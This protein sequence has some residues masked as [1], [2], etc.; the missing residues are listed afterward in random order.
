MMKPASLS[1]ALLLAACSTE[2]NNTPDGLAGDQLAPPPVRFS[3]TVP[4]LVMTTTAR[5]QISGA[6]AN[7][8][9]NLVV[10]GNV[11]AP[12]LCPAATAPVC[13]DVAN[14]LIS[15]GSVM[16]DASGRAIFNLP[17]PTNAPAQVEFQAYGAV[18]GNYA[19]SNGVLTRVYPAAGDAD[20]DGLSNLDE[21]QHG[22]RVAVADTDG[23]GFSDGQER[24]MGTD[25]LDP[26]DPSPDTD[27]DGLTDAEEHA[28]GTDPR[29]PDTD[30][31]GLFDG[32]ELAAGTDPLNPDTDA[33]GLLDGEEVHAAGTDPTNPDTDD[34]GLLDGEEIHL[35]GTDPRNPDSD[36][37]GLFDGD[38]VAFGSDPNVVDTDS[39]GLEDGDEFLYDT[40]P[41]NPDTD[42]DGLLDGAEIMFG[43]DPLDAD[44]D[45]DGIGDGEETSIGTDPTNPDTDGGGESDGDEVAAGRDPLNP[46]DDG[47]IQPPA[48]HLVINEVDY[49]MPSTDNLEFI[50]IFNPT[51]API[52]LNG[53]AVVL[54]NGSNS[55]EYLR[56]QLG[57]VAPSL[58][59]GAYLVVANALVTVPAGTLRTTI[60]DN[61]V[62][63]GAPDGVALIDTNTLTVIDALSYEG[64]IAAAIITGFPTTVSLVEGTATTANDAS[65]PQGLSRLPNGTD[66]NNA[67]TDWAL[68]AP[69]PGAANL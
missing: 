56:V 47:G 48:G 43:A 27:N 38:E 46:A 14:P 29:N 18:G 20:G 42:G 61:I 22:T 54:V 41:T 12:G 63:N 50:E 8:R 4:D 28:I 40:N 49:D 33:D 6:P 23:D 59:P 15:L 3:L 62:Q 16:T 25:P 5:L 66:T 58:A 32:D 21:Q 53:L 2:P 57:P 31:D 37:D 1:V 11:T 35:T 67:A 30:G 51:A 64:S 44:T 52:P 36:G 7:A 69:T 13:L 45:D 65:L 19:L 68:A 34:D 24:A 55:T 9:I 17:I 60:T 10:S 26:N 39:D